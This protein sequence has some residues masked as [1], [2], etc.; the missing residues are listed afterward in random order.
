MEVLDF[1]TGCVRTISQTFPLSAVMKLKKYVYLNRPR[2]VRLTRQNI[3]LR[4]DFQCQYC[5]SHFSKRDLTIDHVHPLSK[6][7][8]HR[9]DNVVT[10]CNKCNNRKGNKNLHEFGRFPLNKPEEP[11]WLPQSDLKYKEILPEV[12]K[13]YLDL[14]D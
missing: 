1:H 10:A 13:Q 7:G 2:G 12:W 5:L 6:G 8:P 11:K 4:D 3:F 9:W 14:E